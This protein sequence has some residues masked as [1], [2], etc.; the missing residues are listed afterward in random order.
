[1]SIS[2]ERLDEICTD[3]GMFRGYYAAMIATIDETSA[4]LTAAGFTT[5]TLPE[6]VA[7]LIAR[8]QHNALVA[9]KALDALKKERAK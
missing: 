9:A 8:D 3:L 6:Q 5:G 7:A 4:L 1:M 2:I